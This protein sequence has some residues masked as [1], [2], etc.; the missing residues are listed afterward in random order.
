MKLIIGLGNPGLKYKKTRH[1]TGWLVLDYIRDQGFKKWQ[2]NKSAQTEIAEGNIGGRKVILAKPLTH[3]NNSGP[4]VKS[5]L[6]TFNLDINPQKL[7]IIHD[8]IDIA[9]GRLK[10]QSNRSAAGHNGVQSIINNLN[11][12][13][14]TRIR[15]G[16]RPTQIENFETEK[17]VLQKFSRAEL[18]RLETTI[19]PD[20]L[21]VLKL[22]QEQ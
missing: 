21:T 7:V 14:F 1:N 18:K 19:F 5:L 12:T 9:F 20:I 15:V 10:F 13:N 2:W 4:A 6:K 22:E 11:T 8:D 3:M 16:I 17:Y